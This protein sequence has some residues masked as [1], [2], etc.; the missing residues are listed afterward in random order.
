MIDANVYLSRWPFRRLPCD[1]PAALAAM[2]RRQGVTEAWAGTF[3]A[4]LHKDVGAA[5]AR[6]AAECAGSGGLLV[7][8][9]TV[10]PKLPDWEEDLRRC[11]E[12]HR[13]PGIR[14]H[15]NY[16]GYALD[17]PDFARLLGLAARR[18]L[19]VQ[20]ALK[21]EDER[22][23]HPLVRVPTV[24]AAPLGKLLADLPGAR[25][26]VLNGLRD[27]LGDRLKAVAA[28]G[29]S[30]EI[31]MLEGV[32]GLGRLIPQVGAA[33][34]LFG[35]YSPFFVF[36]SALLKLRESVLDPAQSRAILEENARR[37]LPGH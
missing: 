30:F 4:L 13:M 15:P 33:R 5:N 19:V 10:N 18:G 17:D 27:L 37:L 34:L 26:V 12:V 29:A 7:P 16:H 1:E 20:V 14:L 9:G 23:Q 2:L 22:T 21:M 28:A 32:G 31:S 24:D 3:D 8:F 25:V 36:E 35:S 11:A 6:L